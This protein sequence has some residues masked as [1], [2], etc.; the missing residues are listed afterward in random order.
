MHLGQMPHPLLLSNGESV[1][2]ET[3]RT[4]DPARWSFVQ[5]LQRIAPLNRGRSGAFWAGMAAL[6]L[7]GCGSE[8]SGRVPV[9]C[10]APPRA[11][12][13]AL[14]R[15]PGVVRLGGRRLSACFAPGGDGADVEALGL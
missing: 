12:V 8:P 4:R 6:V 15:A 14:A 11:V 2:L 9:E 5:D 10:K 7:A 13:R 1:P 3:M